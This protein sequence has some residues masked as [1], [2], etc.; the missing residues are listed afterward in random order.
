MTLQST[1]RSIGRREAIRMIGAAAAAPLIAAPAIARGAGNFRSVSLINNRTDEKL[2]TAYWADGA[3]IPE[4]LAAVDYIMRDW[5]Q[6]KVT[7]MDRQTI[8]IIAAAH[9]MLDCDEPFEV[10]SGYRTPQTN[11][12]LRSRSRGVAKNSYH[13]RGMAVDLTLKSRSV[14]QIARAGLSINAGGVG[15]YSRSNF[16]HFDSGPVRKWGR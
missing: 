5:R 7:R 2:R 10:V 13:M 15:R 16:V 8:D 4:A 1:V 11:A 9:R 14:A 3:Y 12:M 6:D